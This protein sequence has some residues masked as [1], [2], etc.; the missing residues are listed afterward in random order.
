MANVSMRKI[1][2][3]IAYSPE[4]FIATSRAR[5]TSFLPSQRRAPV[6]PDACATASHA[7]APLDRVREAFWRFYTFRRSTGYFSLIFVDSA[8]PRISPTGSGSARCAATPEIEHDIQ[9]CIDEGL[10]PGGGVVAP[11]RYSDCCGLRHTAS[12]CSD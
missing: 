4:P 1:A 6:R 10:F 7:N 2:E 12:R 8:V 9:L 11:E 5:K 3:Q